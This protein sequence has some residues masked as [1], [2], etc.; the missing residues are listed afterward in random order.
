[1][2][3]EFQREVATLEKAWCL[4]LDGGDRKMVLEEWRRS[5]AGKM[6]PVVEGFLGED[7][8]TLNLIC[9]GWGAT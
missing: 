8:R 7:Y 1:M 5:V 2:G 9:C 6:R 3:S 4:V